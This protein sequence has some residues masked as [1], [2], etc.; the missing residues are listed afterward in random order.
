MPR[1]PTRL[2]HGSKPRVA[3]DAIYKLALKSK[4]P[5]SLVVRHPINGP[6]THLTHV[7]R[8]L[9]RAPASPISTPPSL[10]HLFFPLTFPP[11]RL[12]H[13]APVP[14]NGAPN[15]HPDLRKRPRHTR[16]DL[17][18]RPTDPAN[19]PQP[20]N[21]IDGRSPSRDDV[22]LVPLGGPV[23]RLRH[24]A[25]L[26]RPH[27]SAA[28]VFLR[29]VFGELGAVHALRARLA[30]LDD[31]SGYGDD[32][33]GLCGR[34]DDADFGHQGAVSSG[35][36]VAGHVCGDPGGRAADCGVRACAV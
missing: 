23:W 33:G 4:T 6:S 13:P 11:P 31:V 35:G 1:H 9:P 22:P 32:L 36:V 14:S 16:H 24:R 19:H 10:H 7:A 27:P 26:Q 5:S 25:A 34:T 20:P 29:A 28:A 8:R 18:V 2:I 12:P 3:Y 17:L 21:E 15:L 30:D